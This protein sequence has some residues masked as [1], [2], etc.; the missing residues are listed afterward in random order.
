MKLKRS[1]DDSRI[2]L[3]TRAR[4]DGLMQLGP[5]DMTFIRS[6]CTLDVMFIPARI[7]GHPAVIRP[8]ENLNRTTSQTVS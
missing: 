6:T 3:S 5:H 7:A 1:I 2:S 4:Y 8:Q